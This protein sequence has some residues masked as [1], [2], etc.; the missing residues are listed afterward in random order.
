MAQP[1]ET[2]TDATQLG[3][4]IK[5]ERLAQGMRQE[6]LAFAAGVSRIHLG[7]LE[8]GK[9]TARLDGI[10]AVTSALGLRLALIRPTH[11]GGDA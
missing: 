6:D 3:A 7:Q 1:L 4:A 9:P 5:A 10:L 2:W 11:S 8:A